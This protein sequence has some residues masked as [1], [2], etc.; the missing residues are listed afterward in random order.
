MFPVLSQLLTPAQALQKHCSAAASN[1][2]WPLPNVRC[3]QM[4]V[5]ELTTLR[6]AWEG[7]RGCYKVLGWAREDARKEGAR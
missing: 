6:E 2:L 4:Q 5:S 7:A 1:E 3:R